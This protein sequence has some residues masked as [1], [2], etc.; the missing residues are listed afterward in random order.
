MDTFEDKRRAL[1]LR[2]GDS[3]R[4]SH[5]SESTIAGRGPITASALAIGAGEHL[6][7]FRDQ[8]NI[9]LK[10]G[11]NTGSQNLALGTQQVMLGTGIPV[12]RHFN[13]D[14]AFYVLQGRGTVILNDVR[15][16]FETGAAV[17]IPR[18]TWHA[19]ENPEQELLLLWVVTPAGLDGF[20]RETCDPPGAPRKQLSMEQ[21]KDIARTQYGTEYR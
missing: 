5:R 10:L 14:E 11:S 12:H 19:F 7:H 21:I 16:I 20:F 2:T 15:H 17:F 3:E 6:L 9:F 13:M 4:T 18:S 8:G 1:L